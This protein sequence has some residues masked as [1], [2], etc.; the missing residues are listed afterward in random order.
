MWYLGRPISDQQMYLCV[1]MMKEN[2]VKTA[3]EQKYVEIEVYVHESLEIFR[4]EKADAKI[5]EK[6][7]KDISADP[8][9]NYK[10]LS[11]LR[12]SMFIEAK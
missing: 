10:I 3:T 8:N 11:H 6:L 7:Q 9:A 2:Y 12:I 1:C 4:K 5:Y